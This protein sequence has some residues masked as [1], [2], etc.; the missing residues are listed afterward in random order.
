MI[1]LVYQ[2]PFCA[3]PHHPLLIP[4][5]ANGLSSMFLSKRHNEIEVI[6]LCIF[7][8]PVHVLFNGT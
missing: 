5:F 3:A 6:L 8:E 1:Y 2:V 4:A 7:S